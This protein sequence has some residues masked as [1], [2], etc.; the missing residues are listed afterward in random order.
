MKPIPVYTDRVPAGRARI[1]QGMICGETLYVSGMVGRT[2]VTGKTIEGGIAEQTRQTMENIKS[3]VEAAGTTM[4]RVARTHCWISSMDDF[5]P[6]NTVWE[7]YFP[8]NPPARTCVQTR[9]GASFLI[10][11]EAIVMMPD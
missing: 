2:P 8:T 3:V 6:F 1:S 10:E 11:I 4:D 9:L 7:S 5:E